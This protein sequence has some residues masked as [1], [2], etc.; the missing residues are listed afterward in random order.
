MRQK[1]WHFLWPGLV[2]SFSLAFTN[3]YSGT[4]TGITVTPSNAKAGAFSVY[5]ITFQPSAAG[6]GTDTGVP[7]DGQIKLTFPAG[8]SVAGVEI[9]S[10]EGGLDGGYSSITVSGQVVTLVRDSTG[11]ALPPGTLATFKIAS[12][13]NPTVPGSGYTIRL[14]TLT[15][16]GTTIDGPDTSP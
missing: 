4:L 5:T 13:G 15:A 16:T 9:A 2:L 8:F 1:V 11:S 14:E 6:N 7:A 10:N 3:V 12:V